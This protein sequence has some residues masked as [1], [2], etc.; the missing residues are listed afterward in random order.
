MNGPHDLGT[1]CKKYLGTEATEK[2]D[3]TDWLKANKRAWMKEYGRV[4]TFADAPKSLVETRCLF[5]AEQTLLLYLRLKPHVD[6][7]CSNLYWTERQLMLVVVDMER[8]GVLID[9]TRTKALRDNASKYR[10]QLLKE[11]QELV[12]D[13]QVQYK[14][15]VEH[16][17]EFN[18]GSSAH[19]VAAFQKLGIELRYKTEAKKDKKTRTRKGGGSWSFDESAMI[20]YLGDLSPEL[21]TIA[22]ES[23][24]EGWRTSAYIEAVEKAISAGI[25]RQHTLPLLI[26]KCNELSK[27][28]STY[29]DYF[30]ENAQDVHLDPRGFEAGTLYCK[31]NQSTAGT[32]R[33]SS[34]DPNLQNQP[35]KLG[36][37]ECFVPRFGYGNTHWDYD[38]V[39]MKL[40]VHFAQDESMREALKDDI[41][42]YAAVRVYHLPKE[43]ITSEKRK[44]AKSI[45]FGILYGAKPRR[46][47]V[48]MTQ[49]GLSTTLTECTTLFNNYHK[50]FPS[51][52]R[53]T[54]QFS[55]DLARDGFC[56]NPFGRRYHVSS[57]ESYIM[58]NYMCQGTSADIMKAAMVRVWKWLREN[59]PECRLLLTIHDEIII[60]CPIR[61]LRRLCA[62]IK[63]LMEHHQGFFVPITV[64]GELVLRRWSEKEEFEKFHL[65]S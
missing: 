63:P 47:A 59:M 32:G 57:R 54:Q 29:Y 15:R 6:R 61:L 39:E 37:R 49:K 4:P 22:R 14:N 41:H 65:V 12:G 58:L 45:G 56:Q 1:L 17:T 50:A 11:V 13:L 44:R 52:R 51:I 43:E 19:K 36:P 53:V 5:D 26:L 31:L 48:T 35:R 38:Q 62:S 23:S 64:S 30:I 55:L 24:E 42:K 18:P 28:I 7:T 20:R 46:I 27:L 21:V 25:P 40:F 8:R 60:E 2:T 33:F 3:V 9:L 10:D 34:S 16:V